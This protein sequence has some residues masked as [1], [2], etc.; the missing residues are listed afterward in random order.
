M[1][2]RAR[3]EETLQAFLKFGAIDIKYK[4]RSDLRLFFHYE[5]VLLERDMSWEK[6]D[7]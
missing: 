2:E 7:L 6:I 3:V 4:D 5:Q 1:K